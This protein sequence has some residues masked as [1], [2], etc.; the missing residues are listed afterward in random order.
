MTREAYS[1]LIARIKEGLADIIT[2]QAGKIRCKRAFILGTYN[3]E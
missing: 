1:L 3:I 2:V